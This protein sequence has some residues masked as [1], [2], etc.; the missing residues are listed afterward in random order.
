MYAEEEYHGRWLKGC[1]KTMDTF[2][3][4]HG[5]EMQKGTQDKK[6]YSKTHTLW[7]LFIFAFSIKNFMYKLIFLL[8]FQHMCE[9][10]FYRTL[11][12]SP[13]KNS[14]ASNLRPSLSNSAYYKT[15]D[16]QI[17]HENRLPFHNKGHLMLTF[18]Y[19]FLYFF[20]AAQ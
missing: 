5:T 1:G 6:Q 19:L 4:Q 7:P 8:T 16:M 14:S 9:N 12:G 15:L 3:V 10:T 20:C 18:K 13:L 17:F 2:L 11:N